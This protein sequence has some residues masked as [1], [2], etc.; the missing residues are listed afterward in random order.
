MAFVRLDKL[1]QRLIGLDIDCKQSEIED[2]IQEVVQCIQKGAECREKV[3]KTRMLSSI[4]KNYIE[5]AK[6]IVLEIESK[7]SLRSLGLRDFL[8]LVLRIYTMETFVCYWLNELLRSENWE[9]INVLTPCA[10]RR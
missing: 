1:H 9:E 3:V 6:K 5:E 4:S 10:G 7:S 2:I 8:K